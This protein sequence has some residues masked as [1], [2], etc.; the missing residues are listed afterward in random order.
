MRIIFTFILISLVLGNPLS[1]LSKERKKKNLER[2]K[3]I[4]EC[5]INK[6]KTSEYFKNLI[7][8]ANSTFGTIIKY[9]KDFLTDEDLKIFNKCRKVIY[10][11]YKK[12]Y[13]LNKRP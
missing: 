12:N 13:L 6:N 1:I 10:L 11:S 2:I 8:K 5:I 9:H 7:I 3:K 4:K